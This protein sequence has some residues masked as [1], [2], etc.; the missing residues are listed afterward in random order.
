MV[1]RG[2]VAMSVHFE[3][4]ASSR[5]LVRTMRKDVL[6]NIVVL[7]G[8]VV[9]QIHVVGCITQSHMLPMEVRP[10]GAELGRSVPPCN[11]P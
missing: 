11:L 1:M 7:L 4:L 8:I 5:G 2:A 3:R 6:D 9:I 10:T